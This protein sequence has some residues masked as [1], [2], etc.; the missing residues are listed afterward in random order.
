MIMLPAGLDELKAT[1]PLL[2]RNDR[3]ITNLTWIMDQ[4]ND[5]S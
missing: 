4:N 5:I 3:L 1:G 2:V